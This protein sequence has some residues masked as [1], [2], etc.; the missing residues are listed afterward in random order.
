MSQVNSFDIYELPKQYL[1]DVF[2]S[3]KPILKDKIA[4]IYSDEKNVLYD[5]Q[6]IDTD[7]WNHLSKLV[8]QNIVSKFQESWPSSHEFFGDMMIVRIDDDVYPYTSQIAE[9]KLLSHPSIRLVLSDG[10]VMGEFRI[11]ELE[12]IGARKESTIFTENIPSDIIDTKVPN[13]LPNKIPEIISKGD[14]NPKSITQIIANIKNKNKLIYI[15]F[16]TNISKS[17]CS[18]L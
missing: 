13:H 15:F 4:R 12:V 7:W 16:P 14:P 6:K 18:S 11:R 17:A 3:F 5:N 9:A 2:E 1:E 10:G 8:G